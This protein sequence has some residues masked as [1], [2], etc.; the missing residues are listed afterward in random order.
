[1]ALTYNPKPGETKESVLKNAEQVQ[2]Y[3]NS[4]DKV[5]KYNIH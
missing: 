1:M 5:K 3:L 2:K 4:K